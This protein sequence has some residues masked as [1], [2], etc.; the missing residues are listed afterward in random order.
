[1]TNQHLVGTDQDDILVGS[2]GDDRLMGMAG[3]DTLSGG[4]GNDLLDGGEGADVYLFNR[5]DGLDMVLANGFVKDDK[6]QFGVGIS[7]HDVLVSHAN[8]DLVLS[9]KGSADKVIVVGYFFVEPQERMLIQFADGIIWDG[10]T[11]NRK[12]FLS[13]DSL[14]GTADNDMIDGGLGDDYIEGREGDDILYGASGNDFLN[15]GAGTDTY[16]FGLGDGRDVILAGASVR[17]DRVQFVSGISM[18][19]VVVSQINGDLILGLK[20]SNATLTVSSYFSFAP[21]ER[22]PIYFD[23]GTMWDGET[24][25]RK[26]LLNHDNLYGTAAN[27]I[28]DGGLG[29]D[30]I[31]G[32]EGDD[33]LYGGTGNDTLIGGLG[34]DT[35]LFGR[36]D[37][38][39]EVLSSSFAPDEMLKFGAGINIAD[40]NASENNG[41]L[42]LSLKAS[43]DSIT[44]KGY[45]FSAAPYRMLIQFAD[46]TIWDGFT[47]DRKVFNSHD[48]LNGTSGNDILDGGL[49]NDVISGM[50]GDNV[51]Y[52]DTGNDTLIGGAG[53]DT[54]F[55][56]RGD[57]RDLVLNSGFTQAD[58]VQF[59]S[60]ITM[61]DVIL[62]HDNGDLVLS[63]KSGT[64]TLTVQG[65]FF[66][67]P[68]E[69]LRIQ[70]AD[71]SMWDGM[72]VMQ[73]LNLINDNLFGTPG[74]DILD[75]GLGNDMI[76]AS[77]GDDLLYGDSGDDLLSGGSGADTYL[78]GRGDG[79]DVVQ[80]S[81]FAQEDT[82]K[83]TSDI[84]M[85]DVMVN[86]VNGD[87]ILSLKSGTDTL[88]VE[89]YFFEAPQNRM[90]IQFADGVVWDGLSIERKVISSHDVL[91]GTPGNDVID[92][93]LGDDVIQGLDGDDLLYGASGDDE[94]IGGLGADTYLFSRGDGHDVIL[95]DGLTKGDRVQFAAGITMPDVSVS[96]VN[97]DLV[98]SLKSGTETLTLDGYFFI[99]QQERMLIQFADGVI[100]DGVT[101]ERNVFSDDDSLVGSYKNETLDGGLGND[102]ISGG[103]GDDYLYGGD[104]DDVMKGGEGS[105][106]YY[107]GR[108]DGH[109]TILNSITEPGAIDTIRFA[110]DIS[111]SAVRVIHPVN[112]DNAV[113]RLSG[114]DDTLT[115][116]DFFYGIGE[117][118][119][120][121]IQFADGTIWDTAKIRL[122]SV[123]H[124]PI[125]ST[126]LPTVLVN[127]DTALSYTISA[128]TFI[129]SDVGDALTYS[130]SQLNG[131]VLPSWI[132][133]DAATRTLSGTPDNA[134][135]ASYTFQV[136][137][138]DLAGAKASTTLS[139]TVQN[140]NDAPVVAIA[141][142][143]QNAK[144]GVSFNYAVP[145]NTFLDVDAGDT[146]SY[147]ASLSDGTALPAWLS[148][149]AAKLT[150]N[151]IPTSA[152]T[153]KLSI[154]LKAIDGAGL[155]GTDV[156]D[157][158]I[159][160]S[161]INGSSGIDNL[162]GTSG[163]D[164][165]NAMAGND[166]LTGLDGNDTLNGGSG[167]DE[168]RG[169]KGNDV[170][171]VDSLSDSVIENLN[172]GSDSIQSNVT[173]T[174]PTNV[175]NLSL[176]GTLAINGTGNMASNILIGNSGVNV[177]S[178]GAGNDLL[179]GAAGADRLYGGTGNDTYEI[180]NANDL[181]TEYA[182]EGLDIVKSVISYNLTTNL[183]VLILTGNQAINGNGNV[184]QNLLI[185]NSANNTLNGGSGSD[186]LQGAAGDDNLSDTSG[187]NLFDG[188]LGNDALTGGTGKDLFIGGGGNDTIIT[189]TG[190]DVIAFNRGDGK[191]VINA[192]T[193]KDNT[194]SLGHGITYADLFLS[195]NANDL[196]L[197]TGG[198]EQVTFK[199]WYASVNNH[200]VA[201]LQI[202][203]EGTSDYI[204]TS[205]SQLNKHKIERFN[206]DGLVTAFDQ[207][208]A[209]TPDLS[210]WG[211][212][213]ALLNYYITS[214]DTSA[215]GGDLTYQYAMN[216]NLSTMSMTP[217]LVLLT[218]AAFGNSGQNLQTAAALLDGTPI[219]M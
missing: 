151:G 106:T 218:G 148:F 130:V 107:F 47:L 81:G 11:I 153:G 68:H 211:L 83:F 85:A 145:A 118:V 12:V 19:D 32:M 35:Y 113:L 64:D 7:M 41:D 71:G 39:D 115:I 199:D 170:Y 105:D 116:A 131:D 36:G 167:V 171:V 99:A 193:G 187:N 178:G 33:I 210:T 1:M 163:D 15:G 6:V 43:N 141:V 155:F 214:G 111:P 146:L 172:E 34:A 169:G 177:L 87:L 24:I 10:L 112:S 88:T 142:P 123:N 46:G 31:N 194:L 55:F 197:L 59:A 69:N 14:Y 61:A 73:K 147:S 4:L 181:V 126:P 159:A 195:K 213:S 104:G 98:L 168:M 133:F 90:R 25:D 67:P 182:G 129:D 5:G 188:G 134:A 117:S 156:F 100:W 49:G 135:V 165:I 103:D 166:K 184:S 124:S 108:G 30:V 102:F 2:E 204:S 23:D 161:N 150:F 66:M 140:V 82:V 20:S 18:A 42:V 96:R 183:E 37:G 48:I 201:N 91:T 28:L 56:G 122:L 57:G 120:Q 86:Q 160:P 97:N 74:N 192:S 53:A 200:S 13:H 132:K 77:D 51:L 93:G 138:S 62:N 8:G 79:N 158:L 58:K 136:N 175:E 144:V 45:F 50:E 60:D 180:E 173:Y 179:D 208:R 121:Q 162:I 198:G 54:Y 212:S 190:A 72:G 92:G 205:N 164:Q 186:L 119:I 78:F 216:G 157:V 125:L 52:G 38:R 191:D 209:T 154:K 114:S 206:F 128:D 143:D 219:L 139:L 21:H 127:E 203:I 40:V 27:D 70:F 22:M 207:A 101:V 3:N 202:V 76:F 215:I 176:T 80:A 109:D 75:G 44:L 185:G 16:L 63:L 189:S 149:D 152:G 9:L 137:A 110:Y 95:N 17:E 217:A 84:T 29:N 89:G 94:L 26:I 174:L 196:I 65:Y